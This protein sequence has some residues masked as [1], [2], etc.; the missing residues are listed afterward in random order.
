MAPY[1][2]QKNGSMN[3][4]SQKKV[5]ACNKNP[6]KMVDMRKRPPQK[7][8]NIRCSSITT[9]RVKSSCSKQQPALLLTEDSKS[10]SSLLH[11]L[12]NRGN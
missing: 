7:R 9:S 3:I 1:K 10:S 11:R 5:V 12:K 4:L 2:M 6:F 8:H